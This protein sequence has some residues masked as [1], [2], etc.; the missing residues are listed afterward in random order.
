LIPYD[1]TRPSQGFPWAKG[2]LDHAIIKISDVMLWKAEALIESGSAD[3]GIAI[4]NEIRTRAKNSP[5]VYDFNDNSKDAA[6]YKIGLYPNG[7]TKSKAMQALKMERRL[8]LHNEGHHFYDL[9][10]WGEAASWINEYMLNESSKR[11]YYSGAHF[12]QNKEEY[13]PIPQ[14]EID[15]TSGLYQQRSGY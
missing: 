15:A 1:D 12:D 9:V 11:L 5:Y 7:L 13:L 8:E 3:E 2:A 4:I 6:N 14:I 10:R